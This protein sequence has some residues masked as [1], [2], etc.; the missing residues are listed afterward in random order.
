MIWKENQ[1]TCP[2]CL[3]TQICC[4][5]SSPIPSSRSQ[6]GQTTSSSSSTLLVKP[7][8]GG[9][10]GLYEELDRPDPLCITTPG[11][12]NWSTSV[13]RRGK[14]P[15]VSSLTIN[16]GSR[17]GTLFQFSRRVC[18][19]APWR[20]ASLCCILEAGTVGGPYRR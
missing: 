2:H 3:D 6:F 20:N 16:H 19:V 8:G 18:L 11:K 7:A 5:S 10:G 1:R 12:G 13:G 4:L 14:S 17:L 9:V 15:S